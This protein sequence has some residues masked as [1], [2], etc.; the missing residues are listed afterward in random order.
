MIEPRAPEIVVAA[1]SLYLVDDRADR[2]TEG[3]RIA[4]P[5]I[6]GRTQDLLLVERGLHPDLLEILPPDGKE[7]IGIDQVREV[8]RAAQF[9][10]VQ[11]DRKVCVIPH[12]EA[13]TPE[14]GNALL[15]VLEEPPRG[16]AFVLLAA[17]PNDLLPTI[18]SRSRI[19]RE[20]GATGGRSA[21]RAVTE[22]S[23]TNWLAGFA[24]DQ[25]LDESVDV[26]GSSEGAVRSAEEMVREL[27]AAGVA[28]YSIRGTV[29]ERRAALTEW[30]VRCG[31]R[32]EEALTS[33]VRF[34]AAQP[35]DAILRF[36]HE[37]LWVG[38]E[39]ARADSLPPPHDGERTAT[40]AT[41]IGERALRR[42]CNAVDSAYRAMLVYGPVDPI[43]L[44]TCLS[45]G[46]N[47]DGA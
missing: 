18:V 29:L 26:R 30:I 44:S 28:E 24:R 14:A 33:G 11:G 40:V 31:R 13:L 17:H 9:T 39:L 42:F 21:A 22:E 4:A 1:S 35:R 15:K 45:L 38:W 43:L 2:L 27:D 25:E 32:D 46:G 8:I 3:R 41:E 12:A 37:L 19:V 7:R 36:L 6:S 10:P 20:R 34:L 5:L 47:E 16:F 23:A